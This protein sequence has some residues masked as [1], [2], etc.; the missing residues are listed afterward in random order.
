VPVQD[1]E[2]TTYL[3]GRAVGLVWGRAGS[4]AFSEAGGSGLLRDLQPSSRAVLDIGKESHRALTIEE[5]GLR[6][7]KAERID[8]DGK[9]HPD[10]NKPAFEDNGAPHGKGAESVDG[11]ESNGAMKSSGTVES[12][13]SGICVEASTASLKPSPMTATST[14]QPA[15]CEARG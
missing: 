8:D 7:R 9:W 1:D 10:K 2:S 14:A 11:M 15:E 5:E 3:F 4:S 6:P 13:E 12:P